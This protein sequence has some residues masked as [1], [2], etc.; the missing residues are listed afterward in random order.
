MSRA[1]NR[2]PGL[3]LHLAYPQITLTQGDAL[4]AS[5]ALGSRDDLRLLAGKAH[6]TGAPLTVVLPE[7]EVWRGALILDA[8]RWW[9]RRRQARSA[10]G[11]LLAVPPGQLR[12]VLGRRQASGRTPVAAVARATMAETRAFLRASG[13]RARDIVAAGTFPGFDAPPRLAG[14]VPATAFATMRLPGV[15]AQ[16][17]GLAAAAAATVVLAIVLGDPTPGE[18]VP[19]RLTV[20]PHAETAA[21]ARPTLPKPVDLASLRPRPAPRPAVLPADP[22]EPEAGAA[23]LAATVVSVATRNMP[24]HPLPI[25]TAPAGPSLQ[26]AELGTAR[27]RLTDS[28]PAGPLRRP[29][30]V[31]ALVAEPPAALAGP[32]PRSRPVTVA[33]L[34]P[35]TLTDVGLPAPTSQA[36][37]PAPAASPAATLRPLPRPTPENPAPLA[38]A[39]TEAVSRAAAAPPAA[40]AVAALQAAPPMPRPQS[41]VRARPA[42]APAAAKPAAPRHVAT[43]KRPAPTTQPVRPA[44]AVQPQPQRAI[45]AIQRPP[46]V[47]LQA[48]PA[49]QQSVRVAAP[50]QQQV[51]RHVAPGA[52]DARNRRPAA[53][54]SP[55]TLVGVFGT[56]DQRYALLQMPNGAVQ[57][58]Q[59]GD[60]F[61]GV[62]V[63]SVSADSVR[64][65]QRSGE[66]LLRLPD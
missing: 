22:A 11:A 65:L 51:R 14:L 35:A 43:S 46:A 20:V 7:A 5:A 36:A 58:V 19:A 41:L 61:Q 49:R 18:P 63:A 31:A 1:T 21:D 12:V 40:V 10:V 48:Q 52:V 54:R 24:V 3:R 47:Q 62:Q 25:R 33:A 45:A 44:A 60:S 8:R 26:L 38:A 2:T 15:R 6:R 66:T 56:S 39:I 9:D 53:S 29:D 34:T 42:A 64:L 17:F 32:R 57:R 37:S 28:L 4:L 13:L 59:P 30:A 50:V 23:S 16:L 55:V 27:A